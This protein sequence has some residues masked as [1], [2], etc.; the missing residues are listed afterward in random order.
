MTSCHNYES[1]PA[2]RRVAIF[3]GTHGNEMSGVTL[4]NQWIKNATE[5]QRPGVQIKPFI[6]NPRAVEKC[7]RY[8]DTDLNRAFTTENLS[9]EKIED[10]PYEVRRAHEINRLF[11]PKG[12]QDAYDVIFDLHN[13]TS[14]M[15]GTLILESSKDHCILQMVHYVQNALIPISC[16]VLLTEHP[17]LRYAAS[18]SVA[19]CPIGVEVGPQPHGTIRG[20]ILYTMKRIIKH[21]LDFIQLFNEGW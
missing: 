5:I 4:V 13:T 9:T 12:S 18:R 2:A 6:T 21:A 16:Y 3:G 14:N 19:K 8:I 15:G 1:L 20:D 7:T 17:T 11:G 10:L